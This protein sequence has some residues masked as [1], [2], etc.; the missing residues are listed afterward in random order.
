MNETQA[1]TVA[2][3]VAKHTPSTAEGPNTGRRS[4]PVSWRFRQSAASAAAFNVGAM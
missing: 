4:G 2:G 1:D 3:Q